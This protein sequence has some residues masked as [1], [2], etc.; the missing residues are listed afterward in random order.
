MMTKD[1]ALKKLFDSINGDCYIGQDEERKLVAKI[2]EAL[3][4]PAQEPVAWMYNGNLHE[5]NP[6]DWATEPV[7]PLYPHPHQW[8][9]LTDDEIVTKVFDND[10]LLARILY[11]D[12]VSKGLEQAL[13]EKNDKG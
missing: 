5:F 2:K 10:E 12:G 9:G 6:S 7:T 11:L 4:Q 3:E 8:Q 1:E 13:K